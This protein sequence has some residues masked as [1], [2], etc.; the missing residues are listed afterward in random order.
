ML[1]P[2]LDWLLGTHARMPFRRQWADLRHLRVSPGSLGKRIE[3]ALALYPCDLLFVHR[4]AERG[5]LAERAEENADAIGGDGSVANVPVVPVRM[6]EAWFLFD[7]SAIRR[8]ADNPSGKVALALPAS[9]SV[10]RLPDPK[11]ALEQ[12]LRAASE[13]TG[14]R[15]EKFRMGPAKHRVA[16]LITDYSPLRQLSAFAALETQL[17]SVLTEQDWIRP[18]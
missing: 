16:E 5:T 8:A 18:R 3:V 15:L 7:E 13:R 14:R 1:Q 9:R 10:E 2:V 11:G 6:M 12:L 17:V 4:D